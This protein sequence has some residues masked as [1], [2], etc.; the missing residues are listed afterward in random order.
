[1]EVTEVS[2]TEARQEV[3][4]KSYGSM[5]ASVGAVSSQATAV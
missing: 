2:G 3:T 5:L 4:D 1:M